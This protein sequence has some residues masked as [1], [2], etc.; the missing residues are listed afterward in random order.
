[1]SAPDKP[2]VAA[3]FRRAGPAYR[4]RHRLDGDALKVMAC[5]EQ[6]RTPALGG[7]LYRCGDC[8]HLHAVWKSCGNR[9]CPTCQGAAAHAWME[10]QAACFHIVFTL[11]EPVARIAL[12]NR[13]AVLG[14]LFR[15][16]AETLQVISAD[17][18]RWSSAVRRSARASAA[19]RHATCS[20]ASGRGWEA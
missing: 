16:A 9:H 12:Q 11:P 18:R 3:T 5:I 8:G 13:K 15:S 4:E 17:P 19:P 2:G 20:T 6:C 14:I 1:M 10:R 7:T